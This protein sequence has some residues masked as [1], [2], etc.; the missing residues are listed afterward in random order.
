VAHTGGHSMAQPHLL[1]P[2]ALGSYV[3]CA[4]YGKG[5]SLIVLVLCAVARC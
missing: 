4:F 2:M 1:V 3:L 5:N